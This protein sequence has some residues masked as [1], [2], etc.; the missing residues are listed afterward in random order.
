MARDDYG[1]PIPKEGRRIKTLLP[2]NIVSPFIMKT[3]I[4][5]TNYFETSIEISACEDLIRKKRME[6][7]KGFGMLHV[8]LA[9]YVRTVSQLPGINRFI[10][11]QRVYA[12]NSIELIMMVK[13]DMKLDAQETSAKVQIKPDAT[14]DD[15]YNVLNNEIIRNKDQGDQSSFDAT[16]RLLSKIPRLILKFIIWF[17]GALDY[18]GLLPR[19]LVYTSCFHGSMFITALGSLGIPPI[20]H[21]LYDFGNV[22]VFIAYGAKRKE[23]VLQ[24]DGTVLQQKFIDMKICTDE[25]ICD[26]HYMATAFKMLSS[27]LKN[28][29]QLE[30]PPDK[31]VKDID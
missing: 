15:V 10:R 9:A 24:K 16:A 28:P 31:V 12:R 29:H 11:G 6:G 22:P 26:G 30:S 7:L 20:Y 8:I 3:R 23:N 17:L 5:A 13:K 19:K 14:V 18:F 25:R 4:G 21:H 27:L 2:V 1:N